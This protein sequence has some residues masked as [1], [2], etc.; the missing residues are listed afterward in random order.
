MIRDS[1][2]ILKIILDNMYESQASIPFELCK[3]L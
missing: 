2:E 1:E 3:V